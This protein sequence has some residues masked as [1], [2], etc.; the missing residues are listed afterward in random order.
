MKTAKQSAPKAP[1]AEECARLIVH[2]K[3]DRQRDVLNTI[4][5]QGTLRGAGRE[6]GVSVQAIQSS[7]ALV[8]RHAAREGYAPEQD[9]NY[10]LPP[11]QLISGVSTLID[12]TTN[13]SRLQWVKTTVDERQREE[14]LRA[15]FTGLAEELPRYEPI[16]CE[17]GGGIDLLNCYVITDYHLGMK[18]WGAE[19]GADWDLDIA[20]GMLIN[21][22]A[23]AIAHAPMTERAVFAQLGD[24]LHWDG[25]EPVTPTHR[26]VLDA[27][28]RYQKLVRVAIR[29]IRKVIN[30]LLKKHHHLHL[31][32]ADANHD[33]SGG[34]WL[35]EWLAAVYENEPRISVETSPDTYYCVEHGDVS[36]FFHHGHKRGVKEIDRVLGGR[37]RE[38]FGRTR[39]SFAHLGHLHSNE[40]V[41]TQLMQVERHRTL[42]AADAYAAKGGWLSGRDAKVIT[43]HARYGEVGRTIISPD[44]VNG[45]LEMH[46]PLTE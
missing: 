36:L 30:M 6:L 9:L 34:A 31:I 40:L 38:V 7:L 10:P 45:E 25:Y 17:G 2:A 5:R 23:A 18:A 13:T 27:D 12:K 26:H 41:E 15:V 14:M 42:A 11:G 29:V 35:R 46:R 39:Y 16:K 43:Y 1:S 33:P 32:M 21:W 3:T 19:T 8:K 24:F 28:T 37:F 20:E 22:F 4:A 44:M